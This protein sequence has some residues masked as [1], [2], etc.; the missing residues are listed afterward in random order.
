M[1]WNTLLY[2]IFYISH[3]ILVTD[4]TDNAVKKSHVIR[5]ISDWMG[6]FVYLRGKPSLCWCKIV[7]FWYRII[8][9]VWRKLR[10]R[11][12]VAISNLV[13]SSVRSSSVYHGLPSSNP[14]LQ[15]FQIWSNPACIYIHNSLSF[16]VQYTEQNQAILLHEL[17]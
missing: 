5:E 10:L 17:H 9:F 8:H 4:A 6:K 14:L 2:A 1:L 12:W 16:S 11:I 15:I 3:M 13:I 7:I